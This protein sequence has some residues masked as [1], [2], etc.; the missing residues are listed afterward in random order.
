MI[1]VGIKYCGGCN[2]SYDRVGLVNRL[3]E[4][5]TD[6]IAIRAI[7]NDVKY[8]AILVV[9]GCRN[10]CADHEHLTVKHVKT[11]I[12]NENQYLKTCEMLDKLIEQQIE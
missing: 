8:D 7:A 11:V 6:K 1:I 5:Y 2:P 3:S 4:R 10:C 9:C 12:F